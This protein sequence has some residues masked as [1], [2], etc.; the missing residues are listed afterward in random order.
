MRIS[1]L[2]VTLALISLFGVVER[3]AGETYR[4]LLAQ[5]DSLNSVQLCDSAVC[6]TRLAVDNAVSEPGVTDSLRAALNERLG[7]SLCAAAQFDQA[8]PYLRNA[9]EL[10]QRL[11]GLDHPDLAATLEDLALVKLRQAKLAY[12]EYLAREALA[13]RERSL[14]SSPLLYAASCEGLATI[15][16][17]TKSKLPEAER[18]VNRALS[19]RQK[20]PGAKPIDWS[21]T[22]FRLASLY[23][24]WDQVPRAESLYQKLLTV[25][26]TTYGPED[27]RVGKTLGNLG[28]LYL[29]LGHYQLAEDYL[30]RALRIDLLHLPEMH[31]TIAL[32]CY[33]IGVTLRS[34]D[35]L[36]ESEEYVRR[37]LRIWQ[38][39]SGPLHPDAAGAIEELAGLLTQRGKFEESLEMLS[40]ALAIR[41]QEFRDN[42]YLLPE[43]QANEYSNK[44]RQ[45]LADYLACYF[46]IS[47][48]TATV[49]DAACSWLLSSKGELSEAMFVRA[50]RLH[51]PSDS[52][53]GSIAD[54]IE[55]V[56]HR[57]ANLYAQA[58][59]P[60]PD[61]ARLTLDSLELMSTRLE[62]AFARKCAAA[63]S[64]DRPAEWSVAEARKFLPDS[65]ALVEFL[66]YGG[67]D[68]GE[69]ADSDV[70]YAAAVIS[71]TGNELIDLGPTA[72]TDS[73]V[74]R[75][76]QFANSAFS[77]SV[78]QD[79]SPGRGTERL[80]QSLY[81][82]IW[83]PAASGLDSVQ[84]ILISPD[85]ALNNISFATLRH[86]DQFD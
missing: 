85:G 19:I 69:I 82:K 21:G 6:L 51:A 59:H 80:L 55:I 60:G 64:L 53:T 71:P 25:Y 54:S 34:E 47:E 72:G 11:F 65:T 12:A 67:Y 14:E 61:S 48:P 73:L 70:R 3:L 84:T 7:K 52:A 42:Y 5:A 20:Q 58:Q 45:S 30:R 22:T 57:L 36:E 46:K 62:T 44:F 38:G 66:E 2:I 50:R 15:I 41:R 86:G 40:Q 81:D 43:S 26:E 77:A 83:R 27:L 63:D 75:Y 9:L 78:A 24:V 33:T 32:A 56:R 37:S 17:Y 74:K 28:S 35:R 49:T 1:V 10:Q 23:R 39:T 8:E 68:G 13:I 31:P 29:Y 79:S 76:Q 18:L 4:D 16:S